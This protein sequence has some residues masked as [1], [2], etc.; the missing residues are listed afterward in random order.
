MT[1]IADLVRISTFTPGRAAFAAKRVR[2]LIQ[3]EG[4]RGLASEADRLVACAEEAIIQRRNWVQKRAA[5]ART[6]R[7]QR[8]LA[9]HKRI[10]RL[11]SAIHTNA[12][13]F[14]RSTDE[15][16]PDAGEASHL[17]NDLFPRGPSDI[18]RQEFE[19]QAATVADFVRQLDGRFANLANTLGLAPLVRQLATAN[20]G[21]MHALA[22]APAGAMPYDAIIAAENET[23][24]RL[25]RL[26]ISIAHTHSGTDARAVTR[27]AQL[28]APILEQ[29]A[30]IGDALRNRRA[31]RDVDPDTG[32]EVDPDPGFFDLKPRA[33]PRAAAP[34]SIAG[35][36][37]T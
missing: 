22:V 10:V 6:R 15:S 16:E 34:W 37:P 8:L 5:A 32:E 7:G 2:A 25:A 35:R 31:V 17:L 24:E 21:F 28:L 11:V 1:R 29:D 23:Q 27:R 26:V 3:G 33:T 19:D 4:E 9:L 14:V 18:V 13:S 12:Q 36:S 30:R 20:V